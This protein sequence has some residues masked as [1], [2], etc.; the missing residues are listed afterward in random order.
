MA[1]DNLHIVF[2]FFG[3]RGLVGKPATH[4]P[5]AGIVSRRSKAE[6]AEGIA[7]LSQITRGFMQGPQNVKRIAETARGRRRRHELR[8]SLGAGRADRVGI[9]IAFLMDQSREEFDGQCV[10]GSRAFNVPAN[11]A[12]RQCLF[13]LARGRRGRGFRE[14]WRI[15]VDFDCP[16][17]E[18]ENQGRYSPG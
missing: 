8:K 3:Q 4:A 16:D 10:L 18:T 12:G 13:N 5:G 14:R 15:R 17:C 2:R 9:K 6:V 7:Q 11:F 1:R